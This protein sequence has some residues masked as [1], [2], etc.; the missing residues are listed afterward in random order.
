MLTEIDPQKS[1]NEGLRNV[2]VGT[3]AMSPIF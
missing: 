1:G 3:K 2:S